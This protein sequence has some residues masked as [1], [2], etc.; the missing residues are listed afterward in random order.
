EKTG[1]RLTIAGD[2]KY[3]FIPWLG[4]MAQG[5]TLNNAVGFQPQNT[6]LRIAEV[7]I[8]IKL[9]PLLSKRIEIDKLELKGMT[10]Y[11]AKNKEGKVNWDD[12]LLVAQKNAKQENKVITDS[13]AATTPPPLQY[14]P[15]EINVADVEVRDGH[16]LWQD[17]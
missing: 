11:A 1:R 10:L 7:D 2:I 5:I 16:I 4:V 3:T 17:D 13:T 12:L 6:F 14:Q 8:S 9:L 15:L